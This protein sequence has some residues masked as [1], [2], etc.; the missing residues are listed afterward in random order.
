MQKRVE[1]R[2]YIA[3]ALV[4]VLA[5]FSVIVSTQALGKT[6][7]LGGHPDPGV[8]FHPDICLL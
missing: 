7:F 8:G 6:Q 3:G 2:P 5:T 1:W 4:G